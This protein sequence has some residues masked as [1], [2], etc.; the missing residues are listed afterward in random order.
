MNASS[1]AYLGLCGGFVLMGCG[2]FWQR[3]LGLDQHRGHIPAAEVDHT[4]EH[5]SL[6][7]VGRP[8]ELRI[9]KEWFL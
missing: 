9:H 7:G 6:G 3:L 1:L 4:P 5:I 8:D 2:A